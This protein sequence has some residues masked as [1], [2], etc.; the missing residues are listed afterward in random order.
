MVVRTPTAD[1][2][3]L[4]GVSP[5]HRFSVADYHQLIALNILTEDEPVELIDG[6][7]TYKLDHVPPTQP[8]RFFPQFAILRRWTADEYH[9][10]IDAGVL[11]TE[12]KVELLD[13][14]LVTKM[15]Q[16]VPHRAAVVRLS[17]RLAPKLPPGW[18]L[19]TQCPLT[20]GVT[21]PEPDGSMLRGTDVTFDARHPVPADCGI[22]VEVADSSLAFDRGAKLEMYATASIPIYWIVNIPDRQIEV[23]TDPQPVATPPTYAARTDYT[24]GQS[25]PLVLD[26]QTVGTI[27]AA[28]L[29][30]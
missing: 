19:M 27:P 4:E 11:T 21:E 18:V 20:I 6:Y 10:M 1:G 14:Y 17:T 16:N 25:V 23:Y 26:G 8:S 24:L 2:L 15:P 7:V 30:T 9:R 22:F 5:T 12:D 3:T 29:L 13:G 28:D